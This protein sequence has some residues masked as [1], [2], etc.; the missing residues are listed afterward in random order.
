VTTTP[1]PLAVE[2]VPLDAITEHP[3]NYNLGQDEIVADLLKHFGQWRAAVVQR[4]TGRVLVGNT[5]LRAARALGWTHLNVHYRDVD[6]DDARRILAG[7]NRA[8]DLHGTDDSALAALLLRLDETPTGLTGS[9]YVPDDLAAL[10][11]TLAPP[12]G[13]EDFGDDD[14]TGLGDADPDLWPTLA[15][16]LPPRLMARWKAHRNA[17]RE[18]TEPEVFELLLTAAGDP[19]AP[20]D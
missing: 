18:L 19:D 4:S 13:L 7:D 16:R 11:A 14:R 5:M 2:L 15:L 6:D 12:P 8:S 3:E 1:A 17:H 20:D 9:A 10:L